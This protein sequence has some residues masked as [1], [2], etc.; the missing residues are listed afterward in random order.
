MIQ[1]KNLVFSCLLSLRTFIV[2]DQKSDRIP[3]SDRIKTT[4][5]RVAANLYRSL[6]LP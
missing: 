3:H 2:L 6:E 4:Q 1:F 5:M